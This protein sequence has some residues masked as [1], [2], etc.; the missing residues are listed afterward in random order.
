[1]SRA[2]LLLVPALVLQAYDS[3]I[4]G[5][6][7]VRPGIF[8][9]RGAPDEGTCAAI[10]AH[11]ISHVI[12]LRQD[13][14]PNLNSQWESSRLQDLGVQYLRYAINTRPPAGDFDFLRNFIKDLP[15]GS[16]VLIHCGDGNRA[17]AVACT[18]LVM[19]KGMPL[20]EALRISKEAG[21]QLPET[22]E[23]V[24]RYLNRKG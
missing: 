11:H 7:E 24:R 20:E 1:M 15:R 21:L 8:V 6:V 5:A 18:W 19:D 22:E 12:D 2:L 9:L 4:P 23:A 3:A 17:A 13:G 10:K 14:D 16:K